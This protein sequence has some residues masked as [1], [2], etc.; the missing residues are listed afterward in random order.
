MTDTVFL[1]VTGSVA[2]KLENL[3]GKVFEDG[4]EVKEF[5]C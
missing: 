1:V 3:S 4:G 2:S 5:F